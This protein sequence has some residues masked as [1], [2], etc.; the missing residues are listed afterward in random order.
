MQIVLASWRQKMFAWNQWKNLRCLG[1][2]LIG[3]TRVQL[4]EGWPQWW[5][6]ASSRSKVL[7][8][9]Q[10]RYNSQS[11]W[12]FAL[13]SCFK[14]VH[15][16]FFRMAHFWWH[17]SKAVCFQSRLG[18]PNQSKELGAALICSANQ[19]APMRLRQKSVQFPHLFSVAFS[20]QISDTS[21]H[22][23]CKTLSRLAGKFWWIT[24]PQTEE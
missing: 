5:M 3:I 14:C 1:K 7:T 6:T 22:K 24:F 2:K 19:K 9:L 17:V 16:A 23:I 8:R 11:L 21:V 13:F 4:S 10:E 20:L 18:F 15:W 12:N